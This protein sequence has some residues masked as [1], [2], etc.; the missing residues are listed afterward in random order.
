MVVWF[1]DCQK[2]ADLNSG[3]VGQA[4][5]RKSN[6]TTIDSSPGAFS[7]GRLDL[8]RAIKPVI[9]TPRTSRPSLAGFAPTWT[10]LPLE[11]VR[12]PLVGR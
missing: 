9:G 3:K 2:G 5:M 7:V 1:F 11:E 12:L 10:G 6:Y 4:R 8:G